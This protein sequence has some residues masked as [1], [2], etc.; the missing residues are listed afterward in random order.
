MNNPWDQIVTPL[1]DVSARRIDH[2]H[3]LDL[4]WAKDHTGHYLFIYEFPALN[5][6]PQRD[7]P[8]INGIQIISTISADDINLRRLIILLKEQSNWEIFIS[9]CHDLI[10]ASRNAQD[11]SSAIQIILRRLK[12][13]Q[14]FLKK[15]RLDILTEEEIKGLLGELLFLKQYVMPAFGNTQSINFWQGPE[16][17]PQD[18]N[19]N[20]SAIEIKC[21]SGAS[22]HVIKISSVDQLCPT[23]PEMYLMVFT[24]GKSTTDEKEAVNLPSLVGAIRKSLEETSSNSIERFNDLLFMTGYK[25]SD[26]YLEFSYILANKKMYRVIDGFPRICFNQIC[27]GI[28]Q[29]SYSINLTTCEQF[30]GHPIWIEGE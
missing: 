19:I 7:L 8:D 30:E 28:I 24:L 16:G 4:F 26:R 22:P 5:V 15:E 23:L 27:L 25:D 3:P 14:E 17:S 20:N 18:F 9:L 12:R 2:T 6:I 29:L 1:A 10:Q 13:W 11:S 21:H